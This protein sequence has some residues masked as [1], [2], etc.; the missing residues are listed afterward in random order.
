[1]RFFRFFRWRIK[2]KS[3]LEIE[4]Q[5][6]INDKLTDKKNKYRGFIIFCHIE[7]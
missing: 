5:K 7:K 1:M 3:F 2:E 6:K 4:N